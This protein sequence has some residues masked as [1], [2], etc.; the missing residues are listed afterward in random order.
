MKQGGGQART[1][2]GSSSTAAGANG[3]V[4][5]AVRPRKMPDERNLPLF[6][7]GTIIFKKILLVFCGGYVLGSLFIVGWVSGSE[8]GNNHFRKTSMRNGNRANEEEIS[9]TQRFGGGL[10]PTVIVGFRS[11]SGPA[12]PI[13]GR[14]LTCLFIYNR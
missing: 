2:S 10:E 7:P 1:G 9:L 13:L 14:E 3:P 6:V 11:V 12:P 8:P 5:S 4:P